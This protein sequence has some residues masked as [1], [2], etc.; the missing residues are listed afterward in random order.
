MQTAQIRSALAELSGPEFDREY[1]ARNVELHEI[2]IDTVRTDLLPAAD[3]AQ[4][5][6]LLRLTAPQLEQHLVAARESY[7]RVAGT[8]VP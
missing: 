6:E 5:Q 1:L 2:A 7:A 3:D 8:T 4:L